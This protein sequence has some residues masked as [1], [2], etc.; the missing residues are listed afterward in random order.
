[1][2]IEDVISTRLDND[3]IRHP[4]PTSEDLG[5][6]CLRAIVWDPSFSAKVRR[7]AAVLGK[8]LDPQMHQGG[9]GCGADSVGVSAAGLDMAQGEKVRRL[10]AV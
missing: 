2:E 7:Q 5:F 8:I 6:L 10:E 9:E 3:P 4:P 1:M